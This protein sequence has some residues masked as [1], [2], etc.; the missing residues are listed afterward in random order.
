MAYNFGLVDQTC[1]AVLEVRSFDPSAVLPERS[2]LLD[3]P[4]AQV[5]FGG[6]S[7][8]T[9]EQEH[10][11]M[12]DEDGVFNSSCVEFD[13]VDKASGWCW[14]PAPRGYDSDLASLMPS[15]GTALPKHE[16]MYSTFSQTETWPWLYQPW[17]GVWDAVF[18]TRE[19]D[20]ARATLE[21]ADASLAMHLH[22]T[23]SAPVPHGQ[24]DVVDVLCSSEVRHQDDRPINLSRK[25]LAETPD[26]MCVAPWGTF[27]LQE[28]CMD[29]DTC[30][31]ETGVDDTVSV[32]TSMDVGDDP[33]YEQAMR[34]NDR[35]H[36]IDARDQEMRNLDDFGVRQLIAADKVPVECDIFGTK[37]VCKHKRGKGGAHDKFKIRCVMLGNQLNAIEARRRKRAVAGD[38]SGSYVELRVTAPT[39]R[40]SSFKAS[41]AVGVIKGMRRRTFDVTAAYLQGTQITRQIYVRAPPDCREYDERGVEFVWL[42]LRPLYGEPDAG[43]VWYN[44]FAHHMIEKEGFHRSDY[45]S[46]IFVKVFENGAEM[47]LDLYVDDGCTWDNDSTQADAFY[48]RLGKAFVITPTAGDFYLG[49]DVVQ[50]SWNFLTLTSETYILG[51]CSRELPKPISTYAREWATPGGANLM[52]HYE[53][54]FMLHGT[55]EAEFGTRYRRVVGGMAW[56]GPTTRPD[57]LHRI[58]I[59]ARAYTFPTEELYEDAIETLV[60]LGQT[61]HLGISFSAAAPHAS[62]LKWA[63]DSDWSVRRS[64]TGTCGMLA[65]GCV[66]ASSRRQDCTAGSTTEAEV[67]AA[68]SATNEVV[69][70]RGLCG[71]LRLEQ[72]QATVVDIDNTSCNDIA[73][74]YGSSNKTRH[75][76]RRHMRV[77]EFVHRGVV[78]M[79]VV[80]SADNIADFFTKALAREPFQRHRRVIMNLVAKSMGRAVRG[81]KAYAAHG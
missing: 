16:D 60:Y 49:M 56:V 65:G 80:P 71:D 34:S 50:T 67:I 12:V 59:L 31:Y 35:P 5:S 78:S 62:T 1:R 3:P 19:V 43:R 41:A 40:H 14:P 52:E 36:W 9:Y 55:P 53:S 75:I 79:N 6:V 64:T 28:L 27:S 21:A 70:F 54:A 17:G 26:V 20:M 38:A 51:L 72:V 61:A 44:T 13:M 58:G 73:S 15:F 74:D 46:C 77:R 22:V 8:S 57:V 39:L 2:E 4:L 25:I 32:F 18:G 66:H 11:L 63:S 30:V 42:L 47:F 23:E 48:E 29:P 7:H 10:M 81:V 37:L 24:Y 33:S 69:H 76:A 68:S 45:D